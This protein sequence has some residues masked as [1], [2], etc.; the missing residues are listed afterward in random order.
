MRR[1]RDNDTSMGPSYNTTEESAHKDA[2]YLFNI[3]NIGYK[4]ESKDKPDVGVQK[5]NITEGLSQRMNKA[6]HNIPQVLPA[7]GTSFLK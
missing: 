4:C 2:S 7:S 3:S 6:S 5:F 1:A